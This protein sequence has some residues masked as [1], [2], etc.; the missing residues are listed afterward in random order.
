MPTVVTS[1]LR[2]IHYPHPTLQRPSKALRRVDAELHAIVRQ[3][4]DLTYEKEHRGV[5]LAANQVD[6]P[7]RL[8]VANPTADP[9]KRDQEMV[10]INPVLSRP[11]G[12]D[13]DEEGCLSIPGVYAPVRRPAKVTI[14]AYNLAGEEVTYSAEGLLARVVQ[15][16]VDHL[17]G[18]LFIDRLSPTARL[19]LRDLLDDLEAE[20]ASR[21]AVGEI[22]SDEQILARLEELERQRT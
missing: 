12:M 7:Y 11:K 3:M 19:A 8:F 18:V 17:D 22:P 2:I 21:R 10:F 9:A 15:H 20:F 6:L 4:F 13:E 1:P 16:E 14:S 5:G